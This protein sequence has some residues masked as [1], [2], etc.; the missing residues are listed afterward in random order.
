MNTRYEPDHDW[1]RQQ[2]ENGDGSSVTVRLTVTGPMAREGVLEWFQDLS[3]DP[4][5]ARGRGDWLVKEVK[6]DAN[7][8]IVDITSGGEDVS[9]GLIEGT[10]EA[11]EVLDPLGCELEWEQLDQDA[12]KP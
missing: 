6:S 11:Y 7:S 1:I 4:L 10:T 9:K 3:A 8:A 12:P 5:G 2:Q